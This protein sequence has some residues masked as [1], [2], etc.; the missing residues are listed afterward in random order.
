[1]KGSGICRQDQIDQLRRLKAKSP[2]R[3]ALEQKWTRNLAF[4]HRCRSTDW[5]QML[6]DL[7]EKILPLAITERLMK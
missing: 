7:I 1:M 5:G 4:S 3:T 6:D 2:A